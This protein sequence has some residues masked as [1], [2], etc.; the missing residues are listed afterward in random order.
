MKNKYLNEKQLK[1]LMLAIE[2]R[3]VLR[4]EVMMK[5]T[6]YLGLRVRELVNIELEDLDPENRAITIQG[7]KGG[8]LRTYNDIEERLWKKL[9]R[10]SRA[11]KSVYLFP[12]SRNS[13]GKLTTMAVQRLFKFYAKLAELPE[14]FSIHSLRHSCGII[15]A[16][17]NESPIRIMLHLRHRSISSTQVYFEQVS[18]ER[19]AERINDQFG[20]YL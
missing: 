10:Y 3:N 13:E 20:Q 19:D 4:D 15:R 1:A 14:H 16:R 12:S 11:I 6:L 2:K 17:A 7:V 5:L 8:R 18:F 9:S